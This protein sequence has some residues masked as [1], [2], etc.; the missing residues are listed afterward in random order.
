VAVRT[1][2]HEVI[3]ARQAE[4][5]AVGTESRENWTAADPAWHGQFLDLVAEVDT[6]GGP[7]ALDP[8]Q[9]RVDLMAH[10]AAH[11]DAMDLRPPP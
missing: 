11:V 2:W 3:E 8:R 5:K 4:L 7:G 1:L 10:L 6:S 9:V